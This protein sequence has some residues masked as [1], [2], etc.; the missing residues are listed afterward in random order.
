[1]AEL[2]LKGS[3]KKGKNKKGDD[4]SVTEGQ[5]GGL[6]TTDFGNKKER[7]AKNKNKQDDV[8]DGNM[9]DNT[10]GKADGRTDDGAS[11]DTPA[12]KRKKTRKGNANADA[13]TG[14]N[15]PSKQRR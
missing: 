11:A 13:D 1:L 10:P 3:S 2:N 4:D 7:R 8:T 12:P 15:D 6:H 5:I 14:S 9:P